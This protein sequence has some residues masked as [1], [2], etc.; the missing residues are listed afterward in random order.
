MKKKNKIF[1]YYY[2]NKMKIGIIDDYLKT[3]PKKINKF[4]QDN[5][6]KKIIKIQVCRVPLNKAIEKVL[7]ILTLGKSEKLKKNY[8]YDNMFHLYMSI[9]LENDKEYIIEKNQVVQIIPKKSV[10]KSNCADSMNTNF[11]VKDLI[12][13]SEKNYSRIYRYSSHEDNCQKFISTL[14][15]NQGIN[16]F[17]DFIMQYHVKDILKGNTRKLTQITTDFAGLLKRITGAGDNEE[18]EIMK[19]YNLILKDFEKKLGNNSTFNTDLDKIARKHLGNKFHGVYSS[20]KIPKLNELKPY[21]II[22]L[23]NSKQ[24][25][26]HW[27]GLAFDRKMNGGKDLVVYDS[28][29]R[30]TKKILPDAYK[31]FNGSGHTIKDTDYDAEQKKSEKNCGQRS[32]AFLVYYNKHGK[33]KALII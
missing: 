20:D 7:S 6:D 32:L 12:E 9:T 10:K 5:G 25:G 24:P 1:L 15:N 31:K 29:G 22:N 19:E 21:A 13:D 28:F 30:K 11:T 8:N 3:R 16:K 4:L 14:L 33:D 26:S 17:D 27:V 23:D 18:K 2:I